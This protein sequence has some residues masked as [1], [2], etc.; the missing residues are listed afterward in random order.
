MGSYIIDIFETFVLGITV[1]FIAGS[2]I[3]ALLAM[4]AKG[5]RGF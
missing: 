5:I 2:I 1:I 4:F 3:V